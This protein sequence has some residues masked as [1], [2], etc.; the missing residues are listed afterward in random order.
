MRTYPYHPQV[1]NSSRIRKAARIQVAAQSCWSSPR[2]PGFETPRALQIAGRERRE[3]QVL[4]SAAPSMGQRGPLVAADSF[5]MVI[6]R[7]GGPGTPAQ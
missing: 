6:D 1:S 5:K 3:F 4:G 2:S 7:S